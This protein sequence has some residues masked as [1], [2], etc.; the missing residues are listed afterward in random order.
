MVSWSRALGAA[1]KIIVVSIAW[2]LLGIMIALLL[3]TLAGG[4][5]LT[6]LTQPAAILTN[7]A[8]LL[9]TIEQFVLEAAL[10]FTVGGIISSLGSM[11][12]ILK[13][14]AELFAGEVHSI[15]EEPVTQPSPIVRKV[16]GT[17][18]FKQCSSCGAKNSNHASFCGNCGVPLKETPPQ[19]L[20]KDTEAVVEETSS[21]TKVCGS[22][23]NV[24]PPNSRIAV[25]AGVNSNCKGVGDLDL[26]LKL[27]ILMGVPFFVVFTAVVLVEYDQFLADLIR[28][29]ILLIIVILA[30]AL[31]IWGLS[32]VIQRRVPDRVKFDILYG[33]CG[34]CG[35]KL[36]NPH[37][38]SRC[39]QS[40]N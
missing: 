18:Q 15:R 22:C 3:I 31:V 26:R 12:A 29:N 8:T 34:Y 27:I 28:Q 13:Y 25:T 37:T 7:P 2:N 19:E 4:F 38:C 14:S 11:A 21:K 36:T 24:N 39:K 1:T 6:G 40:Q 30:I 32:P 23:C 10:A 9:T 20:V 17:P 33:F 16:I 35:K 5:A